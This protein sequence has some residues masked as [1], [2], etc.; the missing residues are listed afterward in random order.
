MLDKRR[1]TSAV[2]K[3]FPRPP[4]AMGIKVTFV[5]KG[6]ITGGC[7][8][9]HNQPLL[10]AYTDHVDAELNCGLG[11]L[12]GHTMATWSG[13]PS[14]TGLFSLDLGSVTSGRDL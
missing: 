5:Y 2:V 4:Q 3:D 14:L 1:H 9:V 12:T 13:G 11:G 7:C 6:D 8:I 10:P